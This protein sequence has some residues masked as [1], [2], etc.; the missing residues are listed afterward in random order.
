MMNCRRFFI[1]TLPSQ[2]HIFTY[3]LYTN[4]NTPG[5]HYCLY[6]CNNLPFHHKHIYL[7]IY[8]TPTTILRGSIIAYISA[9]IYPSI[10]N[11]YIYIYTVH[12][13]QYSRQ[14]LLL[15]S[16]QQFTLPSQTHIYIYTV[17]QLQYSGEALLLISLQEF[18]L[19]SQTHIFTYILYTNYNTPG[20]HYCLYLC[21]NLPFHHKHIYLHIY[22]TPTTILQGSIIAY[23]SATIYPSITNTYIYIYTVHQLQYSRQALL[24]ISLQQFTL[25][26]QTHIFTYILY[27]N[28]NTPGKHYCLYLCNNLNDTNTYGKSS[29]NRPPSFK[30]PPSNKRP[31]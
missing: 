24:L 12:Q 28:Y 4:Y 22:C 8:C 30:H 25:P 5:K 2:T 1:F 10:T 17:H 9:R 11:T 14:A 19:P 27:T 29:N 20:K 13:L 26:S 7:H 23:I 6:L 31:L 18:T 3:I 16:L 21:N 15:I